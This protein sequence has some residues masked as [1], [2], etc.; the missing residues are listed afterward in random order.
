MNHGG[1]SIMD[2]LKKAWLYVD[3]FVEDHP[4]WSLAIFAA[5]WIATVYLMWG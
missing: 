4:R 1:T 2:W 5:I 3:Y